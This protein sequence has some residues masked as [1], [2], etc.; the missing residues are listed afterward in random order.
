MDELDETFFV[1][2]SNI[3]ASAT[4]GDTQGLGTIVNDDDPEITINDVQIVEGSSGTRNAVFTVTLSNP[5]LQ[6]VTVVV[7]TAD[8]SP[9]ALG[10]AAAALLGLATLNRAGVTN[11]IGY[12]LI[13][14]VLWVI[15]VFINRATGVKPAEP[16][17]EDIGGGGPQN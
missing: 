17:M 11:L 12:S 6:D 5:S 15:T 14:V 10:V 3:S 8:L 1:N 16:R 4:I 2:L 7:N 13:G 9:V